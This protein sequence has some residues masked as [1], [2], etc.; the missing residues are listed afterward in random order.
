MKTMHS[1]LT[2]LGLF[3]AVAASGAQAQE[4][5][6]AAFATTA[7]ASAVH[8][9]VSTY[10]AFAQFPQTGVAVLVPTPSRALASSRAPDSTYRSFA[11][12]PNSGV[13]APASGS[14]RAPDGTYSQFA[15]FPHGQA[16]GGAVSSATANARAPQLGSRG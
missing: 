6:Q 15:E 12:Y 2:A 7:P 1:A 11:E 8:A 10:N 3:A 16:S 13:A 4:F 9:P 5:P 14:N